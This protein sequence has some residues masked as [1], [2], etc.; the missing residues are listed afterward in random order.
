MKRH[1]VAIMVLAVLA[2]SC[3]RAGRPAVKI[4]DGVGVIVSVDRIAGTIQINHE[5]IKGFMT[6]MTMSFKAKRASL[7]DKI[8]PGDKVKF[9]LRD[10]G[11]EVVLVKID[12]RES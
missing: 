1:I 8:A 5:E 3:C 10:D 2:I 11:S 12:R 4:Y 7:L 9:K 6:A